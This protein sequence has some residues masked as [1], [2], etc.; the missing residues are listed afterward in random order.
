MLFELLKVMGSSSEQEY[1][2]V[3]RM[4]RLDN[5]NNIFFIAVPYFLLNN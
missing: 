5:E 2:I 1:A 3:N 4:R